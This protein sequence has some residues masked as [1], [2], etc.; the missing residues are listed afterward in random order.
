MPQGIA[1]YCLTRYRYFAVCYRPMHSVIYDTLSTR[2]HT[3]H[4]IFVI[5]FRPSLHLVERSKHGNPHSPYIVYTYRTCVNGICNVQRSSW[6]T[7]S[8][9]HKCHKYGKTYRNTHSMSL[10]EMK[11]LL[12]WLL[13]KIVIITGKWISRSIFWEKHVRL[14]AHIMNGIHCTC[15]TVQCILR[16][17]V[18]ASHANLELYLQ[19]FTAPSSGWS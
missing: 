6:Y 1:I 10:S 19:I 3:D 9:S 18:H 17:R 4:A 12:I 16:V 2:S 8:I 15:L 11:Q 14:Q 13:R 5:V 7:D